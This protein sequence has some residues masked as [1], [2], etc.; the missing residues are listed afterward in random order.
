LRRL[1]HPVINGK[2]FS[3]PNCLGALR[4]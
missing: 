4:N 2:Y 1:Y 3:I